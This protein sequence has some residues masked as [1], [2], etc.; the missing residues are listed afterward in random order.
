M[1]FLASEGQLVLPV[2]FAVFDR[3]IY[4]QTTVDSVL[5]EL[6]RGIDDV[7]FTVT[8]REDLDQSGWNVM[9]SGATRKVENASVL[10]QLAETDRLHPWAPGDRTFAIQLEPRTIGGRRVS[11]HGTLG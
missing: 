10:Q 9:V 2:N 7:A 6:G 4:F 1:G 3:V 5:A 11:Q 8:Y